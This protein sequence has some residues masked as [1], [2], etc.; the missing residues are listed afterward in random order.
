MI[1]ANDNRRGKRARLYQMVD[2]LAELGALAISEPADPCRQTLEMDLL[3]RET[4]PSVQNFVFG[5]QLENQ[6]V[7]DIDVTWIPRECNPAEW[8]PAFGEHRT[9][10]R[11]DETGEV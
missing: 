9:D 5:K 6:I 2:A 4:N 7:R 8:S 10:V 1:T 3:A 11:R